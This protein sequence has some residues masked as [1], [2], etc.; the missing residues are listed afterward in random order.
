M[1]FTYDGLD[2]YG[3]PTLGAQPARVTISYPV[4]YTYRITRGTWECRQWERQHPGCRVRRTEVRRTYTEQVVHDV[5]LPAVRDA[6][7]EG[8]GGWTLD[9]HHR[10]DP[11]ARVLERGDGSL[12][13]AEVLAVGGIRRFAAVEGSAAA[14]ALPD[15]SVLVADPQDDVIRRIAPDGATVEVVAGVPQDVAGFAQED[16]DGTA[17][18]TEVEL[19]DPVAVAVTP[20]GGFVIAEEGGRAVRRVAPDGTITTVAGDGTMPGSDDGTLLPG[21][22]EDGAPFVTANG[23]F[24]LGTSG[25]IDPTAL[26]VTAD[27][28]VLVADRWQTADGVAWVLRE[29][30]TGGVMRTIAGDGT[31]CAPGD[32]AAPDEVPAGTVVARNAPL[33]PIRALAVRP[34][35]AVLLAVGEDEGSGRV[36]SLDTAGVLTTVVGGGTCEPGPCSSLDDGTGVPA[37][38]VSL[39][40]VSDVEVAPDGRLLVVDAGHGRTYVVDV[41]GTLTTFAGGGEQSAGGAPVGTPPTQVHLDTSTAIAMPDGAVLL[42]RADQDCLPSELRALPPGAGGD[43]VSVPTAVAVLA[44]L[45]VASLAL[46]LRTG[47]AEPR[48]IGTTV[49]GVVAVAAVAVAALLVV[50]RAAPAVAATGCQEFEGT[51]DADTELFRVTPALPGYGAEEVLIP[52]DDGRE[53]YT[54]DAEGRHLTTRLARTGEVV[55][56]FAYTD[57]LLTAVTQHDLVGEGTTTTIERDADGRATAVVGPFGQRTELVTGSSGY[58][59]R[60]T[61]PAG[62]AVALEYDDDADPAPETT[63]GGL[64]TAMVD[65]VGGRHM[66]EYDPTGL[67]V[68]DRD[69]VGG[70]T[71]LARTV[72]DTGSDVVLTTAEGLQTV[73]SQRVL[74]GR[75][76]STLVDPAGAIT[77]TTATPDGTRTTVQPDGTTIVQRT[78]ADGRFGMAA[79]VDRETTVTSPDGLTTTTTV[80]RGTD[81]PILDDPFGLEVLTEIVTTNGRTT[82]GTWTRTR[83]GDGEPAGGQTVQTSAEGVQRTTVVDQLER[84]TSEIPAAGVAPTSFAYDADGQLASVTRGDQSWTYAYDAL[85]RR[86]SSTDALGRTTRWVHEAANRVVRT[87]MPSADGPDVGRV[88][89]VD[90]D[91]A[92]RQIGLTTPSGATFDL[93]VDAV[94][95]RTAATPPATGTY[96]RTYDEDHRLVERSLPSGDAITQS[97]AADRPAGLTYPA[98][99]IDFAYDDETDRPASMSRDPAVGPAQVM[100]HGYD[101]GL[102]T[103]LVLSGAAEAEVDYAYDADR[104]LT[105]LQLAAGGAEVDWLI[106]R[107]ADGQLTGVGDLVHER[108][109]PGRALGAVTA[110]DGM[111]VTFG[112]DALARQV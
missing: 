27:G 40:T 72:S 66:Y 96:R 55:R 112:Y 65:P 103:S 102:P 41:D 48:P 34:D 61:D 81:P 8:I 82:T 75:S 68:A 98:A 12:R 62:G 89:E 70:V 36:L 83:D 109:G 43:A 9:V 91:A 51:G 42:V 54:F 33:P 50:A 76:T 73:Y 16:A 46:C 20:D 32:C 45:A 95:M 67:L 64:L 11:V 47:V 1:T 93:D 108:T 92:G 104:F 85:G 78:A 7:A 21:E 38:E 60:V 86:E 35:G 77:T 49:L 3:R 80:S 28:V 17:L 111:S 63:G 58:L 2:A 10:F 101:G 15:G 74:R 88:I 107:D 30:S 23:D 99:T 97:F 31:T 106:S 52:S 90:H 71:L 87:E 105:R 5:V 53:V 57:G 24:G 26:A 69:P 110:T 6:R 56:T 37:T 59:T 18:A 100:A 29:I 19:E 79:P 4:E 94:G 25:A 14:D 39:A 44:L 84:P 13:A 22:P